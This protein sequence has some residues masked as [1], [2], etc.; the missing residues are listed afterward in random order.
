MMRIVDVLPDRAEIKASGLTEKDIRVNPEV[1]GYFVDLYRK[2]YLA[3]E[4]A[5][6]DGSPS[7]EVSAQGDATTAAPLP[8]AGRIEAFDRSRPPYH[9]HRSTIYRYRIDPAAPAARPII[10]ESLE[11]SEITGALLGIPFTSQQ[12]S[13]LVRLCLWI[14]NLIEKREKG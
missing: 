8:S 14:E 9:Y 10:L 7:A 12:Q 2:D 6:T 3:F 11:R 5:A 4:R 1:Y 13:F